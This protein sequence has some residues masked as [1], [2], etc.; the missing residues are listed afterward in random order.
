MLYVYI[1]IYY[2]HYIYTIHIYIIYTVYIYR[3]TIYI[4]VHYII[5]KY[6]HTSDSIYI[7]TH[8]CLAA[9]ILV[10]DP[11]PV[12]PEVKRVIY[13][14]HTYLTIHEEKDLL[15]LVHGSPRAFFQASQEVRIRQVTIERSIVGTRES[16][17]AWNTLRRLQFPKC[18]LP[19]V[20][21]WW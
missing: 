18:P 6:I 20:G 9:E 4:Y 3:E 14:Y 21:F 5:Y 19:T 8:L 12:K 10:P 16:S 11:C 15:S 2:I 1:Y 17:S 13:I 7:Y